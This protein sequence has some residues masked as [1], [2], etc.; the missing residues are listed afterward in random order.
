M[1]LGEQHIGRAWNW[2]QATDQLSASVLV[3]RESGAR[4]H[5][6]HRIVV[7]GHAGERYRDI[8]SAIVNDLSTRVGENHGLPVRSHRGG[9]R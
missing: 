8:T 7:L 3:H 4:P 2:K 9:K 5:W 6:R 1:V